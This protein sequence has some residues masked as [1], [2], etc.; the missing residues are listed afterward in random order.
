MEIS[1]GGNCK[2][3]TFFHPLFFLTTSISSNP[4]VFPCESLTELPIGWGYVPRGWGAP[5]AP[6]DPERQW[7]SHQHCV[8]LPVLTPVSAHAHPASLGALHQHAHDIPCTRD[9]GDQHQVE[10]AEAV[11]CEPD[12]SVLAAWHPA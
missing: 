3:L 6:R 9:V 5:V 2:M 10:V 11:D 8:W 4:K 12:T 1:H 7:L